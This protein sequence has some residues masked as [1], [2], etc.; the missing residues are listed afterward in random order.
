MADQPLETLPSPS[1][2]HTQSIIDR[3]CHNLLWTIGNEVA[4]RA[5]WPAEPR[6]PTN[7]TARDNAI[8]QRKS[9][10]HKWSNII[11]GLYAVGTHFAQKGNPD[12]QPNISYNVENQIAE[13]DAFCLDPTI[14]E[15][16]HGPKP[17][18]IASWG[19]TYSA[20][21]FDYL[22]QLEWDD[23]SHPYTQWVEL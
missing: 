10:K 11:D 8:A 23:D 13:K 16:F 3:K 4:D 5:A 15:R 17:L 18:Q 20:Y 12:F 9:Q 7:L 1:S 6:P 14:L 21:L 22:R 19:A 2:N